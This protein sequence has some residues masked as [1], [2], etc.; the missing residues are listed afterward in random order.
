MVRRPRRCH[1]CP[2]PRLA[3]LSL[4]GGCGLRCPG[5]VRPA[6]RISALATFY[7]RGASLVG[8]PPAATSVCADWVRPVVDELRVRLGPNFAPLGDWDLDPSLLARAGPTQL[9][10]RWW[11]EAVGKM[12]VERLLAV[13]GPRDQ[14]RL[15]Q[16]V[17]SRGMSTAFISVQPSAALRTLIPTDQFRLGLKWHLGLPLYDPCGS[18]LLCPACRD[19]VDAFGDHLMCC[20]HNNYT[21]R[22]NAMLDALCVILG[23]A[24]VPHR[25]EEPLPRDA[26]PTRVLR[27]AD[28][29]V[30]GGGDAGKDLAVDVTVVHSWRLEERRTEAQMA[31]D[32]VAVRAR[33]KSFLPR[34]EGRK[35]EKY[36][37]ACGRARWTFVPAGFGTWGGAGPEGS[38]LLYRFISRA[39]SRRDPDQ[40]AARQEELRQL[41]GVALALQVWNLLE[42]VRLLM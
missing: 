39:A 32:P 35:H 24:G 26:Q 40:R 11:S 30:P 8:L 17:H 2:A 1:R 3:C 25:R 14:N 22:H 31:R 5:L 37:A 10:Q 21:R 27:P 34:T 12:E 28:A 23:D 18:P 9:Q 7:S 13:A 29:F 38:K 20:R 4:W 42:P 15:L 33:W 19:P 36:D 41:F 6:A 16:Q